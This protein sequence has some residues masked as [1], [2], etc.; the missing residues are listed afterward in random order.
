VRYGY[1]RIVGY[2]HLSTS[3]CRA[4]TCFP[5]PGG[6]DDEKDEQAY[7]VLLFI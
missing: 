5:V 3:A 7:H 2:S 6:F 1:L 4:D